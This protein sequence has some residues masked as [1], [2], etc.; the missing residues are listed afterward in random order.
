M[1]PG[2]GGREEI[3]EM[4]EANAGRFLGFD[5]S[6]HRKPCMGLDLSLSLDRAALQRVQGQDESPS[7]TRVDDQGMRFHRQAAGLRGRFCS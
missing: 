1:G 6:S 7:E 4:A 2:G 5:S 3:R